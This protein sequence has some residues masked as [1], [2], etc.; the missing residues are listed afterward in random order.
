MD[1]YFFL[2]RNSYMK[3]YWGPGTRVRLIRDGNQP[4]NFVTTIERIIFSHRPYNIVVTPVPQ[5]HW[6][7]YSFDELAA[8]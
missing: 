4:L 7:V 8:P 3:L 6:G 1:G 2:G 5:G